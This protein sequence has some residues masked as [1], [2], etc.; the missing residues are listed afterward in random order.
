TVLEVGGSGGK[1][2]PGTANI[3]PSRAKDVVD[4]SGLYVTPGLIDIH[5]HVFWGSEDNAAYSNGYSAIQP[6]DH[7]FRSGQTTLVDA[8][9]S[10]WR[11]FPQFKGQVIDGSKNT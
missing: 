7:S 9:G 1:V 10:G 6:D 8:G 11:S 2:A 5:A 4:A 3:A